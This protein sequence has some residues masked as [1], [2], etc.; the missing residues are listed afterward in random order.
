M[1]LRAACFFLALALLACCPLASAAPN[2]IF[3]MAD[4]LG[5]GD[6]GCYGQKV[7]QTP[8]LDRMA[9]EGTR[10]TDFYAGST[11]CA[12]SRCVLMTGYHTGRCFIR[13]NGKDNLR[14]ADVTVAEVLK[15][16]G[17]KTCLAGKWGP[18]SRGLDRPPHAAGLRPLLRLPRSAPCP[19][20]LPDVSHQ[21]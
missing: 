9:K 10:F 4:D 1:H 20:L 12:P 13:G 18:R 11:V 2:I 3:I 15:A 21:E 8:H 16:A 19:Q 14:P 7:I 5:Y 17:Y 6:L